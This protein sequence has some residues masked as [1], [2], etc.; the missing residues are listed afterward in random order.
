[1]SSGILRPDDERLRSRREEGRAASLQ[2]ELEDLFKSQNKSGR[3]D[4]TSIPATFL[5]V[6]V[7]LP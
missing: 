7:A 1:M 6:T 4:G 3:N 5:R 2:A